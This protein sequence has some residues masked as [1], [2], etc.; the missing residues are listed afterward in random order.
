[1][2]HSPVNNVFSRDGKGLF[3]LLFLVCFGLSTVVFS[4]LP[5]NLAIAEPIVILE[6]RGTKIIAEGDGGTHPFRL[7]LITPPITKLCKM[8]H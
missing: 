2:V 5:V 7:I 8:K 6:Y 4:A 3:G 1:M